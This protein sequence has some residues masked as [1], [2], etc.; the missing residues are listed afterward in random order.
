MF[1][2]PVQ[3]PD[4]QKMFVIA[5]PTVNYHACFQAFFQSATIQTAEFLKVHKD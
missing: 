2:K 4:Q 5:H 1:G 3:F